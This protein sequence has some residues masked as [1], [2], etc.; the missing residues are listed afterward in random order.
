MGSRGIYRDGWMASAFG[1]RI[2]WVPGLPKGIKEWTPDKDRWELY[3]LNKD[4]SQAND[5][6]GNMP[7]KVADMKDLFLIEFTKN[8][9]LPIGGGLWIP[10]LHPELR[11]TPPYTSWTFAG[12]ITRMPEVAAPPSA[13][14]RTA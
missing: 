6:A 12:A 13:T 10:V 3:D 8:K 1:P 4:W 7:A 14:K 11:L 5:L 9:G 2:P